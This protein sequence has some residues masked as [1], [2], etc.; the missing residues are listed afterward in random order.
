MNR[1]QLTVVDLARPLPSQNLLAL[2]NWDAAH[3]LRSWV[4]L[5]RAR[6]IAVTGLL[7]RAPA[8]IWTAALVISQELAPAAILSRHGSFSPTAPQRAGSPGASPEQRVG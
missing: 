8:R 1:N 7:D 5:T 3:L 6:D 4:I 2:N